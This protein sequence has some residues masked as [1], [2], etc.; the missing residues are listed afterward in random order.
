[1]NEFLLDSALRT[2]TLVN[3]EAELA[4]IRDAIYRPDPSC[5]IVLLCGPGGIGKTRLL[6]EVLWRAG[7]SEVRRRAAQSGVRHRRE[8]EDWTRLGNVV[9]SDLIDFTDPRFITRSR[10]LQTIRDSLDRPDGADFSAFDAAYQANQRARERGADY[11]SVLTTAQRAEQRFLEEYRRNASEKRMVLVLDT[12][13]YLALL[14]TS[15]WLLDK[16][17]LK[18][19]DLFFSTSEWLLSRIRDGVLANTTLIIA[20]RD[21]DSDGG[22]FFAAVRQ[23]SLQSTY[24][25]E[26]VD[27]RLEPLSVKDTGQYLSYLA[28]DWED[29]CDKVIVDQAATQHYPTDDQTR[30]TSAAG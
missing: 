1:M 17:I 23:A 29:R 20:G 10:F 8:R 7:H 21:A 4:R 18:P 9:V 19:K 12:A 26:I 11:A 15:K 22:P 28:D 5:Q 3:R 25:T 24:P 6:E 14:P 2:E 13:E 16:G 30:M 27:L